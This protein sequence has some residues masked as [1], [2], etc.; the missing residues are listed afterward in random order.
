MFEPVI[1]WTG[2]KRSQAESIISYFPDKIDV[3]YEPFCG[4]CSVLNRLL[5]TD[6]VAVKRF[7]VSDINKD[8]IA[9]WQMIKDE[10]DKVS[11]EYKRHWDKLVGLVDVDKKREYFESVRKEYNTYH[12]AEDFMFI[13]RTTTNG[14]PRYNKTGEFNNSYHLSRNGITPDKLEKI[15]NAWSWQLNQGQVEFRNCDYSSI[16]TNEGDYIYLDPPYANTKGIYYGKIDY[17]SFFDWLSKQK[18]NW[19][20]SFDGTSGSVDNTYDVNKALYTKHVYLDSGNSSFKRV[21]G[22]DTQAFVKESLY[23]KGSVIEKG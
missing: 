3:Y 2:S 20:L 11:Q 22:K 6:R 16:Q 8:L 17:V 4:G 9:L 18:A 10:P 1:K 12:R 7:V 19:A 15:I 5:Q 21:L 14:M 23:L 13:M